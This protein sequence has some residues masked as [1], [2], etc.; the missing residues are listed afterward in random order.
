MLFAAEYVCNTVE[1]PHSPNC[2]KKVQYAHIPL[3][4]TDL[5]L[6][7]ESGLCRWQAALRIMLSALT[8]DAVAFIGSLATDAPAAS[9]T[10]AAAQQ[11]KYRAVCHILKRCSE[12]TLT[13]PTQR[14]HF[15]A[16]LGAWV[17]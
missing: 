3:S 8:A 4:C 12:H 17:G 10:S 15:H 1:P 7:T 5:W 13:V 6:I 14:R 11:V 16:V 2:L 9:G